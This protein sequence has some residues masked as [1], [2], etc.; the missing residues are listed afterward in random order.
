MT[1]L[2]DLHGQ[3]QDDLLDGAL[4]IAYD[5]YPG[6]DRAL[7][8]RRIDE[9][10]VPLMTP[11][12]VE[13][14]IAE[15]AQLLCQHLGEGCG[16]RGNVDDYYAPE[17]SFIN[18]VLE[19]RTGIPISLAVVYIAIAKR[20]GVSACG[21]GF[22]GHF[23][24]RIGT[25]TAGTIIDPFENRVLSRA[26]LETLLGKVSSGKLE[27]QDSMLAE[28]PTRHVLARMLLNLRH[29]FAKRGDVQHLLVVLDRLVE[30]LPEA[31]EHRRDRGFLGAQFGAIQLAQDDLSAY[32]SALP[33]AS[34]AERVRQ[35]L[36]RLTHTGSER[37]LS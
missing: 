36:D 9:L 13:L 34:D 16:F 6:L 30:L 4:S 35:V 1:S 7:Q 32:L 19:R 22:P 3:D 27:L 11:R 14:S 33:H 20:A 25:G 37:L 23:L 10:A 29:I 5:A 28:T 24:V 12:L 26:D 15:Q 2:A 31:V 18:R 17:N 21:I 8:R